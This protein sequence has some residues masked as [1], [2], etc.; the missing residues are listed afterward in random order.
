MACQTTMLKFLQL[1]IYIYIYA[2]INKFPLNQRTTLIDSETM[3]TFQTVLKEETWACVRIDTDPSHTFNSFL[4][5]FLNIL[6][7]SFPVK[8]K[9]KIRTIGLH[10]E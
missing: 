9:G 4:C 7:A 10:M 1:N 5:T 6:Q 8:Y 3:M 2:P